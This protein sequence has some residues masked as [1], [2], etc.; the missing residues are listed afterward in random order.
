MIEE[1][2]LENFRGFENAQFHFAPLTVITGNNG[3]GK[4]S[5]IEAIYLLSLTTS[6]RTEKDTEVIKWGAPFTRVVSQE[7]ELVIQSSPYLKRIKVDGISK[8]ATQVIGLMPTILFQPDDVQ[9]LYGAPA[10]RRQYLDRV[11]SQTAPQYTQA[12]LQLGKVLKQRNRLL[13]D[14]CEGVASADQLAFWDLQL[15]EVQEIIQHHRRL[16][17]QAVHERIPEVF[18][19]MVPSELEVRLAYHESPHGHA[20]SFLEHLQMNRMK[21][22]A[23]G[24]SLYGPHREDF[25]LFWGEHPVAESMS[26]GQS[27]ALLVAFK[28]AELEYVTE[29]TGIKPI[30][31][32]DDIFSELDAERRERLVMIF[33][34]YQVIMSTTELGPV[35][36]LLKGKVSIIEI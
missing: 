18:K 32:L 2:K 17:V 27:R 29:H 33:G 15:S 23:A 31:L 24:N 10:Y 22:I 25:E 20:H 36:K 26:R 3:A 6:W 28:I 14:I 11:I 9:L 1:V 16:F 4:T 13:K 8:R 12:I 30:L 19:G 5:I 21:E 7:T 35:E 34:E